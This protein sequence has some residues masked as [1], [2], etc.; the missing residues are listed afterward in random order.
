MALIQDF[1]SNTKTINE[2]WTNDVIIDLIDELLADGLN[3]ETTSRAELSKYA[4]D[5][6]TDFF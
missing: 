6:E 3:N 2:N 1:N 4:I 5:F